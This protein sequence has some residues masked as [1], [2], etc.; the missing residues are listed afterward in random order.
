MSWSLATAFE[1]VNFSTSW[2]PTIGLILNYFTSGWLPVTYSFLVASSKSPATALFPLDVLL[3]LRFD[4]IDSD[5]SKWFYR[6]YILDARIVL[7]V[8]GFWDSHLQPIHCQHDWCSIEIHCYK[9]LGHDEYP[10]RPNWQNP[11]N[12]MGK[13]RHHYIQVPLNSTPEMVPLALLLAPR[14]VAR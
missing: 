5:V 14:W 12:T 2:P 7:W 4:H 1:N 13:V 10:N 3:S 6:K 8:V 11:Q 9:N